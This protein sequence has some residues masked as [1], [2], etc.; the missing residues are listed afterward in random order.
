MNIQLSSRESRSVQTIAR[1]RKLPVKLE[2]FLIEDVFIIFVAFNPISHL[3]SHFWSL[4]LMS[5]W[6]SLS[7]P[8]FDPFMHSTLSTK[9]ADISPSGSVN[10]SNRFSSDM[11][12]WL[13]RKPKHRRQLLITRQTER[14]L[15][16]DAEI[17]SLCLQ[18]RYISIELASCFWESHFPSPSEIASSHQINYLCRKRAE[19]D[20]R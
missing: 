11:S 6:A 10:F 16:S 17:S 12:I 15:I 20:F 13:E 3:G 19:R 9:F 14:R 18:T 7:R 5:N 1:N 2:R 4:Q 8:T